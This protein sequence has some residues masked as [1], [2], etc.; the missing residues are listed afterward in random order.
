MSATP[1]TKMHGLGNDF[2]VLDG[3]ARPI[4]LDGGQARALADRRAG[5]GCDQVIVLESSG[6]GVFMRIFNADGGEVEACGN[7]ARCVAA[8][9]MAEA[10]TD[11]VSFATGAGPMVCHAAAEGR[12]TVD[13]G[14]ARTGW[15]DIPLAHEVDTEHL[16]LSS[17]AL[18]DP[19][20]V[21]VGNPHA[22]FFVEDT[23]AIDL[24]S[25]GPQLETDPLFPERANITVCQV[26]GTGEVRIKVWERGAG[27]TRACGTAACATI[28][29]G[30]RRGLMAREGVVHL[31][32]GD[33]QVTWR[34][35]GHVEMTGPT[36]TSFT[37][38]VEIA[39][40]MRGAA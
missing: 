10:G 37:G 15:R 1:F 14:P 34:D 21:N 38:T 13:I 23:D 29:A 16:P 36:A 22:I 27:L 11:A 7:A 35:D 26:L 25:L 17:G 19:C 2:V 12:V 6:D 28:V 40:L 3:R 33:L 20:A 39:D 31:P 18:A 24:A 30:H 32:G 4:A 8:T 5:V 9:L